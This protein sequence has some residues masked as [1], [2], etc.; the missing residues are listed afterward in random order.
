MLDSALTEHIFE[1][2]TEEETKNGYNL[3]A[4]E[5][6][7][8]TD[9]DVHDVERAL[10]YLN[11]IGKINPVDSLPGEWRWILSCKSKRQC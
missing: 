3:K 7:I 11:G 5:L 4:S 9:R 10:R 8:R 2:I 6:A 1:I